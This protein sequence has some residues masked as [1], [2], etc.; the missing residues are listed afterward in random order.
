MRFEFLARIGFSWE[1]RWFLVELQVSVE[2]R[3]VLEF[4]CE[5]SRSSDRLIVES[6]VAE[7]SVDSLHSVIRR[8]S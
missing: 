4:S 1:K 2:V 3:C 5:V 7:G 8:V 6:I